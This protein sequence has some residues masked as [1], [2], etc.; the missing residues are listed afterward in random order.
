MQATTV[1]D[2]FD[3]MDGYLTSAAVN[4]ALELGL[5]WLVDEESME[6][7][8]IAQALGIPV[9][10]CQY[11]LQVLRTTGLLTSGPDGYAPTPSARAAV[12]EAYSQDTWAF[13]ARDARERTATAVRPG[14]RTSPPSVIARPGPRAR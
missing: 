7:P 3:L 4:A 9:K 13:L 10:R 12:L 8:A 6:A 14:C 11:W 5:F 1:D 2:V